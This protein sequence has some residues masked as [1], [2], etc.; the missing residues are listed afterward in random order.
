MSDRKFLHEFIS[1]NQLT[2]EDVKNLLE[3]LQLE[4]DDTDIAYD[5]YE[6][7]EHEEAEQ[8]YRWGYHQC[9]SDNQIRDPNWVGDDAINKKF[10]DGFYVFESG[11]DIWYIKKNMD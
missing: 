8:Y 5:I 7:Y 11:N 4:P 9:Q 3:L 1:E 10:E 2:E 6:R